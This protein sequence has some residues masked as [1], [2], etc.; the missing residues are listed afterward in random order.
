MDV[1]RVHA[2]SEAHALR[3]M[4]S[5]DG[6]FR[7]DLERDGSGPVVGLTPDVE[8]ATKLVE[9][10]NALGKWLADGDLASCQIRFGDRVYTLLAATAGH[11]NDA[12]AFLLERTIQLQT[13]LDSRIVIEQAK[14]VLAARHGIDVD[15]AFDALRRAARSASTKLHALAAE[16][17]A[18]PTTPPAIQRFLA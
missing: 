15:T 13:A 17:V 11:P 1:I 3:L 4:A 8:T 7:V 12:T 14:G 10:F 9:L 18:T 16:V 2:P 6:G 5:L